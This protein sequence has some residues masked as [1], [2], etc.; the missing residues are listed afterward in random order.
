MPALLDPR[1]SAYE[2]GGQGTFISYNLPTP[3]Y[4]NS[5]E[6]NTTVD[7]TIAPVKESSL[8]PSYDIIQSPCY[9]P[10]SYS[11][12]TSC[13]NGDGDADLTRPP[14]PAARIA[15]FN[16][17]PYSSSSSEEG[18]EARPIDHPGNEWMHNSPGEMRYY[19]VTVPVHTAQG[20]HCYMAKYIKYERDRDDP[21]VR[22][23]M[24]RNKLDFVRPLLALPT[25]RGLPRLTVSQQC[26][27]DCDTA[28]SF[29][30]CAALAQL[31]GM[32]LTL[33]GE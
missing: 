12:K 27:F 7:S 25:G 23:T 32:V 8:T 11:D 5:Y 1:F 16:L 10:V 30:C 17:S 15:N 21:F 28:E 29:M 24:G 13:A 18:Q 22:A 14:L 4:I 20:F 26:L 3:H 9:T 19:P 31:T 6:D 2:G 33:L